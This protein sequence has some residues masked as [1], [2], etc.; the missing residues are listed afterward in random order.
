[1]K[2]RIV[3]LAVW[4]GLVFC[5]ATAFTV[6]DATTV[7]A[8][9]LTVGEPIVAGETSTAVLDVDGTLT[10]S[11][12]GE[13]TTKF[14]T[15]LEIKKL[16]IEE[17]ITGFG[18]EELFVGS[19]ITEVSIPS[20]FVNCAGYPWGL[21]NKNITKI[22][23]AE[24]MTTIPSY[25]LYGIK[26]MESITLPSTIKSIGDSAFFN[27]TGLKNVTLPSTIKSIGNGSFYQC[28]NLQ[29][30]TIPESVTSIGDNAFG[31]CTGL[32]S[33]TLPSTIKSIGDNAFEYCIKL[34]NITIPEGVTY[35]GEGAF[36]ECNS[37]SEVTLPKS[38][39]QI[40]NYAFHN[41]TSVEK[42][43][44]NSP[45]LI[46][47]PELDVEEYPFMNIGTTVASGN[48]LVIT[49]GQEVESIAGYLFNG[50]GVIAEVTVP[51]SVKTMGAN[52][53][54]GKT[55]LENKV[56]VKTANPV[57][58]A[59]NWV[60][61]LI[62]IDYKNGSDKALGEHGTTMSASVEAITTL[63][64]T[65]PLES[66]SFSIDENR[67]FHAETT[68]ISNN[69]AVPLDVYL[70]NITGKT[71]NEP[72][73]VAKNTHTQKEWNNLKK[74]ETLSELALSIN[75]TELYTI[76]NNTEMNKDLAISIGSLAS[77]FRE[78]TSLNLTPSAQYGKNFGNTGTLELEYDLVFEFVIPE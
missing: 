43:T 28:Y 57:A 50:C 62:N 4:L 19:N 16:I 30:I 65:I 51:S 40:G 33:V 14:G 32:K 49:F 69:S 1:M 63:D 42:V 56:I 67:D 9:E 24:G 44:V 6:Y 46:Y 18:T 34:Q 25:M 23:L 13:V 17:G 35:I 74:T 71:E 5:S 21:N 47:A 55:T 41:C 12:T 78:S 7:S 3:T 31:H 20:T 70:I 68:V 54:K 22:N 61:D 73:L 2:K 27:C 38:L 26:E 66:L 59:Y 77:G 53:F 39:V 15:N 11:G 29:N 64:V 8:A 75:D 45:N 72:A 60:G 36:E 76:Y 58:M 48:G 10:I 52:I 37:L